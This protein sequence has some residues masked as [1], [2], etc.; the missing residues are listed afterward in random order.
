[1]PN[2]YRLKGASLE[3]IQAKARAQYGPAARIVSAERVISPGIAG[4]FA[5]NR[6]EAVVE[7]QPRHDVVTGEVVPDADVLNADGDGAPVIIGDGVPA[8]QAAASDSSSPT[9]PAAP[10]V[11]GAPAGAPQPA[12]A[13]SAVSPAAPAAEEPGRKSRRKAAK[14]AKAGRAAKADPAASATPAPPAGASGGAAP[15]P[16]A[17]AAT[18]GEQARV[19]APGHALQGDAIAALLAEADAA[20]MT[21]HRPAQPAL[22]TETP[23]FADLLNQLGSGLQ[24]PSTAASPAP[25]RA[26]QPAGAPT[27]TAPGGTAPGAAAAGA[28]TAAVSLLGPAEPADS[29]RCGEDR[30]EAPVVPKRIPAPVPLRGTGDLVVL[31]GLGDDPL[32]TALDMSIAAGG[33]DVR[34]AGELSAYGHLHLDGRQ[35]ATAARAHAVETEQTVIAAFGLGKGRHALARLQALAAL[36]PDQVWVVVDAGRKTADTARWINV[37]RSR[38]EIDAMAVVGAAYTSSPETVEALNIPV[39]WIDGKPAGNPLPWA[40]ADGSEG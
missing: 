8:A 24:P 30:S 12:S 15:G 37:V 23:G 35:S 28:C 11:P 21:M 26:P 27:G 31:V 4:M 39:G 20:E 19:S 22:S 29:V 38:L 18:P 2:R 25:A 16:S 34:T 14:A 9:V 33:A 36:S 13:A 6:Y 7:L 5:A 40:A 10:S 1:M 32:D 3:E 17:S